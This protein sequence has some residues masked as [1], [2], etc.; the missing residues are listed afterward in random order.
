[1]YDLYEKMFGVFVSGIFSAT[2]TGSPAS[3]SFD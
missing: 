1:M 3:S 2:V